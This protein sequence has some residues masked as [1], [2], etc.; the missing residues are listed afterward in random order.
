MALLVWLG[1]GTRTRAQAPAGPSPAAAPATDQLFAKIY[2]VFAHPR[3]AN[4]HGVVRHYPGFTHSVT[5]DTHPGGEVGAGL[6]DPVVDCTDCHDG[7][8]HHNAATGAQEGAWKFTAPPNMEWAG[9]GEEEVCIMQ[10]AEARLKNRAA[11]GESATLKGSYLHHVTHDPLIEQAFHG[12]AGGARDANDPDLPKPPLS[13][14]DF[15]AGAQAWIDAGAPCRA[16]GS[17]SHYEENDAAYEHPIP[18]GKIVVEQHARRQVDILRYAD[19]SATATITASGSSLIVQTIDAGGCTSVTT[20]KSSWERVGPAQVPATLEFEVSP[21]DYQIRYALPAETTRELQT[22]M[23]TNTC[24][25]ALPRSPPETVELTWDPWS[26]T[27]HCPTEF[28][29]HD[30]TIGCVPSEPHDNGAADG[31]LHQTVVNN[32]D[33]LD[34]RS[35][36]Y[37]SPMPIG[38]TDTGEGLP[39]HVK[40][41]WALRIDQ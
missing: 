35:W 3:C 40:I 2:P 10:A 34:P 17:L 25:V 6:P 24:G 18:M 14:G 5:P 11:G 12:R 27:L 15:K 13:Y 26:V 20:S 16:T 7:P 29:N 33:V 28:P 32:S 4:C 37:R 8:Q 39:V 30:G 19:G 41:I 36:L 1:P 23:N 9:L 31:A 22:G 38:R 21:V